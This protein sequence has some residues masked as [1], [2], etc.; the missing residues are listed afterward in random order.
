MNR[1]LAR[2]LQRNKTN[3]IDAHPQ[4]RRLITGIHSCN[5]RP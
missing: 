5:Y 4:K 1:V 2:V 3:R